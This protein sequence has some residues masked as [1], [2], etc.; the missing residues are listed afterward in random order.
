MSL[1]PSNTLISFI[2]E[3]TQFLAKTGFSA[4]GFIN[5][6]CKPAVSYIGK[7]VADYS[8][9]C[10]PVF[11][12]AFGLVFE[13]FGLKGIEEATRNLATFR[14][15][16]L[17]DI[18]SPAKEKNEPLKTLTAAEKALVENAKPRTEMVAPLQGA[19][20]LPPAAQFPPP[21]YLV[22]PALPG[23]NDADAIVVYK[24]PIL[25]PPEGAIQLFPNTSLPLLEEGG[26]MIPPLGS[27]L[28]HPGTKLNAHGEGFGVY[29]LPPGSKTFTPGEVLPDL[30]PVKEEPSPILREEKPQRE[31]KEKKLS[32]KIPFTQQRA[33]IKTDQVKENFCTFTQGVGL[34]TMGTAMLVG[35][36]NQFRSDYQGII[37]KGWLDSAIVDTTANILSNIPAAPIYLMGRTVEL[38]AKIFPDRCVSLALG[39][40]SL[41]MAKEMLSRVD[42]NVVNLRTRQFDKSK[43]LWDLAYLSASAAFGVFGACE[44][45]FGATG[46]N[47]YEV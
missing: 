15:V 32:F 1:A 29:A 17:E 10:S 27:T 30:T 41:F 21:N 42:F 38:G 4:T 36:A 8:T 16:H 18:A 26:Y 45:Y 25:V 33:V 7:E 34:C 22:P 13:G 24:E 37:G 46:Y 35:S 3:G 43:F 28:Y 14:W 19:F 40:S 20:Y 9:F 5:D 11:S 44:M 31:E 2:S 47:P 23:K 12:V 6:Y 39:A